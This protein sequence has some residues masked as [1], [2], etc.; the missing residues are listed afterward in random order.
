MSGFLEI[1]FDVVKENNMINI[2][3]LIKVEMNT[4]YQYFWCHKKTEDSEILY[5]GEKK[6]GKQIKYIIGYE[7]YNNFILI[8][9]DFDMIEENGYYGNFVSEYKVNGVSISYLDFMKNNFNYPFN[10]HSFIFDITSIQFMKYY[11]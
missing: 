7:V 4:D 11:I 3:N 5:F 9:Y 8:E 10:K 1:Y 6:N 2:S